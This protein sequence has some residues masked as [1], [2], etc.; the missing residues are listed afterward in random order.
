MVVVVAIIAILA[1]IAMLFYIRRYDKPNQ[2][3]QGRPSGQSELGGQTAQD[4]ERPAPT[5]SYEASRVAEGAAREES[6]PKMLEDLRNL[7]DGKGKG[8]YQNL[9]GMD[10]VFR[11]RSGV[12]FTVFHGDGVYVVVRADTQVSA[13]ATRY[14]LR[15][16]QS[17]GLTIS[18]VKERRIPPMDVNK[19]VGAIQA[20]NTDA[21]GDVNCQLEELAFV[22]CEL[23]RATRVGVL[24]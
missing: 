24:Q 13:S 17:G 10:G 2:V 19:G 18:C 22:I 5:V 1:A 8:Q 16:S 9:L 20:R 21:S 4:F 7:L 14:I 12:T 3:A 11:H 6:L 15:R 23:E